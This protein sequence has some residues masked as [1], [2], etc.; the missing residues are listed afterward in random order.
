MF[1]GAGGSNHFS[2]QSGGGSFGRGSGSGFGFNSGGGFRSGGNFRSM[3]HGFGGGS[4]GGGSFGG[5]SFGG[6]SFGGGNSNNLFS[7]GGSSG[8]GNNN[9]L[10]SGRGGMMGS[11]NSLRGGF[12][13]GGG[14]QIVGGAQSASVTNVNQNNIG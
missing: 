7:S 8:G 2:M 12:G 13:S 5:G 1:S 3:R 9:N 14:T 4:F 11:L 10:F 6:G